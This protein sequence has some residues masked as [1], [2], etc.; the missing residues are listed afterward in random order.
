MNEGPFKVERS[1]LIHAKPSTVFRYFTDSERFAAWWGKGSTIEGRAGGAVRICYPGGAI[2]GGQV[3][4][5]VLN[6]RIVFTYGYEDASKSIAL[7]ASRV[8]ISLEEER[9]GT[10]LSLVHEVA[11]AKTKAE[12]DPGWR[13]QLSLFANVVAR[14]AVGDPSALID[15]FFAAWSEPNADALGAALARIVTD[16]VV[17]RDAFAALAGASDLASH[18]RACQV[19]MPG[20]VLRRRGEPVACQGMILVDW[21]AG[22]AHGTNVFELAP[23]GRVARVTGFS[24][25]ALRV[26]P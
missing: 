1:V 24:R 2:A 4:E 26:S 25:P 16:D 19:F 14:E 15:A 3:V 22:A 6:Q 12:H 13:F 8:T 18:I 21:D 7:D 23:D 20:V 10:R 11:D 17:F 9:Q 5:L